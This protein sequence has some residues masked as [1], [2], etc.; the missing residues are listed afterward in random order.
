MD[1]DELEAV[2]A[3]AAITEAIFRYCRGLDRMDRATALSLWHPDGGADYAP[4]Y[5]GDA[6]GLIDWLWVAHATLVSHVHQIH[7]VLIELDGARAASEAYF[8]A[9]LRIEPGPGRLV[10][11]VVRG[12]Y[13]DTWTRRDGVWGVDR[14]VVVQDIESV[15]DVRTTGT[16][17][18]RSRRGPDDP[19]YPV[20]RQA[21]G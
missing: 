6:S 11:R 10:D 20:L 17:D 15:S 19:S 16:A 5:T 14:R 9:V 1:A 13:L 18:G 21:S 7:N 8:T 2:V 12:R 4:W 3:R